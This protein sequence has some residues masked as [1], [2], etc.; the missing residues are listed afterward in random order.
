MVLFLH[1][2]LPDR[3]IDFCGNIALLVT[4]KMNEN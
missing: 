4:T 1:L 2:S 3:A